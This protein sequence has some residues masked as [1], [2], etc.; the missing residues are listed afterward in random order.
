MSGCR[1]LLSRSSVVLS[2]QRA[3]ILSP[4]EFQ[5]TP[6]LRPWL[7]ILPLVYGSEPDADLL[8]VLQ[9]AGRVYG[10]S[11][12]RAKVLHPPT[13]ILCNLD[14]LLQIAGSDAEVFA[15]R[16]DR[17]AIGGSRQ[18]LTVRAVADGDVA[19]SISAL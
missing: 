7:E 17:H 1:N 10:Q 4:R 14:V 5:G 2:R 6:E 15:G 18:P 12:V 19:G 9:L 8:A 13:T 16:A 3:K 11:A